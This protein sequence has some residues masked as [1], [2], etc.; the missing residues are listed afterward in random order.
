MAVLFFIFLMKQKAECFR[1]DLFVSVFKKAI[2]YGDQYAQ[3]Y[4]NGGHDQ[5]EPMFTG[6]NYSRSPDGFTPNLVFVQNRDD[7]RRYNG[8]F[9]F[10]HFCEKTGKS[11]GHHE[12]CHKPVDFRK[13]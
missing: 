8:D 9:E 10:E 12:S 1:V 2:D 5:K 6:N 3:Y 13:W 7:G 4:R 11:C